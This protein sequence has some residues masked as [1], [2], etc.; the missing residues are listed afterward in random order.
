MEDI[1]LSAWTPREGAVVCVQ[2]DRWL[3]TRTKS[4]REA[5]ATQ[6]GVRWTPLLR[7]P[8]WDPVKHV[9]LGFMHNWL[10][11]MLEV[12]LR[13]L[14]GIGAPDEVQKATREMEQDEMF[15]ELDISDSASELDDLRKEAKEAAEQAANEMQEDSPSP[16]CSATLSSSATPTPTSNA[17]Q[18]D[19]SDED[20][21]DDD[22]PDYVD[23]SI[24][25]FNDSQIAAIRNCITN[26]SLPTWVQRPPV[27]LG[28]KTHGVLKASELLTLFSCI[29]P[30]IIPEFW[31]LPEATNLD[32]SHLESFHHLIAAMNIVCSFKTSNQDADA[33]T[34][35]YIEYRLSIRNLFPQFRQHPNHHMA[36]HNGAQMKY[37]GPLPSLSEF[38][39]ERMNGMLQ[40]INTNRRASTSSI[41]V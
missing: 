21:N 7:L 34:H 8:Y 24:G 4:G 12:Q 13:I 19:A 37:W 2:A 17:Y 25:N 9:L 36:M 14:W 5:L 18:F 3:N 31:H 28:E 40:N 15:S 1:D 29:F 16:S 22:D 23:P 26:I 39:G 30:L 10:E 38:P 41:V 27:N 6:H 35:H 11:G 32:R 33:Y 20:K